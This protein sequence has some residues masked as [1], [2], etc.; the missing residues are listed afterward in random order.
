MDSLGFVLLIVM[1]GVGILM[2]LVYQKL[3]LMSR[4]QTEVDEEKARNLVNQ[5]FGEITQKGDDL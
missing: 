1:G 3:T 5:V 4:S 2:F